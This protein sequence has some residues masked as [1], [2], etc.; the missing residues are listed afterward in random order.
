MFLENAVS[1][2]N[3]NH[4]LPKLLGVAGLFVCT[5]YISLVLL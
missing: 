5:W 1:F 3:S 4:L 2:T